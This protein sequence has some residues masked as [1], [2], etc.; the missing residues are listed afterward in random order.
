[1]LVNRGDNM[2][3]FDKL[4]GIIKN[5][6]VEKK[7]IEVYEKGLAKTRGEFTSKLNFSRISFAEISLSTVILF[8]LQ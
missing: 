4:K 1:M 7:E 2:G 3:L 5:N 6:K 8:S